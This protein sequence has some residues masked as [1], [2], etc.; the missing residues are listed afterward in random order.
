MTIQLFDKKVIKQETIYV[1]G[2]NVMNR[3]SVFNE[4]EQFNLSYVVWFIAHL[5]LHIS[6]YLNL[7]AKGDITNIILGYLI[8]KPVFRN[9]LLL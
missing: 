8:H 5:N 1:C 3:N 7:N 2:L 4:V 9:K 6:E